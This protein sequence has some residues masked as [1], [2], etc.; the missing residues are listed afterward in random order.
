MALF[1]YEIT[2]AISN[3]FRMIVLALSIAIYFYVNLILK[4]KLEARYAKKNAKLI[5]LQDTI[6]INITKGLVFI[7]ALMVILSWLK[8]L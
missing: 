5:E 2:G 6:L 4:R 3:T 1:S 8:I 7:T